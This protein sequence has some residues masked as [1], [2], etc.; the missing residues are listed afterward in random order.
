MKK[1]RIIALLTVAVLFA[2][3]VG[4]SGGTEEVAP[5]ASETVSSE[6]AAPSEEVSDVSIE[7]EKQEPPMI[8]ALSYT[9]MNGRSYED[10]MDDLY[11]MEYPYPV[12]IITGVKPDGDS[13]VIALLIDGDTY[14]FDEFYFTP[15]NEESVYV[16]LYFPQKL[17]DISMVDQM[18][19]DFEANYDGSNTR[20]DD[21]FFGYIDGIDTSEDKEY[22]E[23]YMP[24][25]GLFTKAELYAKDA[26]IRNYECLVGRQL[27]VTALGNDGTEYELSVYFEN[28]SGLSAKPEEINSY[29][30]LGANLDFLF[31]FYYFNTCTKPYIIIEKYSDNDEKRIEFTG[32]K[33]IAYYD[34]N[35]SLSPDE[36]II[37]ICLPEEG[38]RVAW[39]NPSMDVGSEY[40]GGD[41]VREIKGTGDCEGTFTI[42]AFGNDDTEYKFTITK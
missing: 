41:K 37:A 14:K 18:G 11:A 27:N 16:W 42:T 4:C 22:F 38:M 3:F 7:Q 2:S 24:T 5:E 21:H 25:F 40:H 30:A 34:E 39:D 1:N 35:I 9:K 6:E 23:T 26:I 32:E 36:Y 19:R 29:T 10:L 28:K 33:R 12:M 17:Q 8:D 13:G 31:D 20:G 15:E